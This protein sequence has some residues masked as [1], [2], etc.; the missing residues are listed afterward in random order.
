MKPANA[1]FGGTPDSPPTDQRPSEAR[2]RS[3]EARPP[4][5]ST[6]MERVR[7]ASCEESPAPQPP[8]RGP[9]AARSD[10]PRTG[11]MR[12]AATE[13]SQRDSGLIERTPSRHGS[14]GKT[15]AARPR[16]SL[17][18]AVDGWRCL[19]W[20]RA[21]KERRVTSHSK[22]TIVQMSR[23][24]DLVRQNG[25]DAWLPE[26]G[27]FVHRMAR[28][29]AHGLGFERCRALYLRGQSTV[30]TVS[31]AGATRLVAVSGPLR[32]MTNVLRRAGLE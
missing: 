24:G 4:L 23:S 6:Q 11:V 29:V 2:A 22:V 15:R 19:E 17:G 9:D 3:H 1:T 31:E 21:Q 26:A 14:S 18:G 30:L 32:S 27:D 20:D 13:P 5:E 25:P 8:S 28:L 12:R 7:W 16:A 10:E